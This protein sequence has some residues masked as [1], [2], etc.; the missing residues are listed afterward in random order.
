MIVHIF[1]ASR[2]HLVPSIS[3]TFVEGFPEKDFVYVL[4]GPKDV[5][6]KLYEETYS[7]CNFSNY[8]FCHSIWSFV[9]ILYKYRKSPVLFHAGSYL[10]LILAQ[11][12]VKDVNWICWGGE[13]SKSKSFLRR[14][15]TCLKKV[16]MRR[17]KSI[18][19][20]VDADEQSIISDFG[21][22]EKRIRTLSYL[23][24]NQ[25]KNIHLYEELRTKKVFENEKPLVVLGNNSKNIDGYLKMLPK[26]KMYSGKIRI[27]CMLNYTLEKNEKYY[28][29]LSIGKEVFGDDFSTDEVLRPFTE[30]V[31]H[32]GECSVYICDND[33]QT[34]LG[35]INTCL[36]LGKKVY[37]T[38]KNYQWATS[39]YKAL[40]FNSKTIK[41]DLTYENFL[42]DLSMEEKEYNADCINRE[43]VTRKS[44]WAKYFSEIENPSVL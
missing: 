10:W 18:V 23:G 28:E 32:M 39:H 13:A 40:V 21:V 24:S 44:L 35:A 43:R 7:S 20:L 25:E 38:G 4:Y 26:L 29:L 1:T 5:N 8:L 15:L 30:Y 11:M 36:M 42:K 6:K 3:K 14:K 2:Y 34:G 12:I 9:L 37:I 27:E 22:E 16:V 33:R 17:Y 31:R 41:E 19:T